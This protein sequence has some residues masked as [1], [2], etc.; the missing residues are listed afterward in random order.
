MRFEAASEN[1]AVAAAQAAAR[2]LDPVAGGA[3]R[4]RAGTGAAGAAARRWRVQM[5]LLAPARAPLRAALAAITALALPGGVHRV[6]DVDPQ[7]TV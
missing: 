3:A 6:I 5:L 1:A 7:S 2:A 4:D